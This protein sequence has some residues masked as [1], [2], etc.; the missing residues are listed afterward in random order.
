MYLVYVWYECM[1]FSFVSTCGVCVSI[2][3]ENPVEY[4]FLGYCWYICGVE[5]V[6]V[7]YICSMCLWCVYCVYTV[8]VR[9][10][11][12]DFG[13]IC[14]VSVVYICCVCLIFLCSYGVC[15][16]C[17]CGVCVIYV[18]YICG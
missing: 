16:V 12:V 2:I 1:F 6:C 4:L 18:C 10:V 8:H 7:C 14:Y 13:I 17:G 3:C 9:D 5:C 15:V 11:H